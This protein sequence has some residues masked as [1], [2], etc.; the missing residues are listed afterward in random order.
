MYRINELPPPSKWDR[1]G[2]RASEMWAASELRVGYVSWVL[3]HAQQRVGEFLRVGRES[4]LWA[5]CEPRV[6]AADRAA[7]SATELIQRLALYIYAIAVRITVVRHVSYL[8]L[9]GSSS[10]E[11]VNKLMETTTR[12][13]RVSKKTVKKTVQ[14]KHAQNAWRAPRRASESWRWGNQALRKHQ[15]EWQILKVSALFLPF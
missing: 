1:E 12:N 15:D 9:A 14:T 13:S 11:T 5:A 3:N 8:Q 7:A 6:G 4:E 10:G 2:E